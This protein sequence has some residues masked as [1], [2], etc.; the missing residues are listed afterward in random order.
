M[1]A[2]DHYFTC[3]WGPA[4]RDH[5][6]NSPRHEMYEIPV[7][8]HDAFQSQTLKSSPPGRDVPHETSAQIKREEFLTGN[9]AAVQPLVSEHGGL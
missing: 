9:L 2:V 3:G 5:N 6:H 1:V 4:K 8:I 7:L